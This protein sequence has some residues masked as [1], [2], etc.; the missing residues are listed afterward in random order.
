[1]IIVLHCSLY[2]ATLQRV[3]SSQFYSEVGA[4]ENWGGMNKLHKRNTLHQRYTQTALKIS[5]TV[6]SQDGGFGRTP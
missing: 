1:M 4:A 5:L 3:S 2:Y 6:T